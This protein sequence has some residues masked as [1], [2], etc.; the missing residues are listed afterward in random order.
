[1]RSA[2]TKDASFMMPFMFEDDKIILKSTH[3][4]ILHHK[5]CAASD[6]STMNTEYTIYVSVVRLY[7]VT[8]SHH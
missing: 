3:I 2:R 8:C 4:I 1:M 6:L 5:Y 7:C